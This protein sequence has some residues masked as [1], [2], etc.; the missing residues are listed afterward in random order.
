MG[1]SPWF[2]WILGVFHTF[3]K[4]YELFW[5]CQKWVNFGLFEQKAWAIAHGFDGFWV[6]F[7]PFGKSYAWAIIYFFKNVK[8]GHFEQ[9]AWAI[10]HGFDGFWVFFTPFGKIWNNL[11]SFQKC[12]FWS[13]WAKSMGYSPWF[14]WILGVFHTFW[15]NMNYLS[16][17]FKNSHFWPFL[18]KKH[19]L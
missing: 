18:S 1:Y 3:W 5:K 4:I 6:F 8:M 7:T 17:A 11:K 12:H 16:K 2:W 15:K 13:F 19:G 9:K 10:A 14:W